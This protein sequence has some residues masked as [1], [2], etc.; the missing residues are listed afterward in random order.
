MF[1]DTSGLFCYLHRD[2]PKHDEAVSL[3]ANANQRFLTHN[4]VITELI[5][6]SIIR[7][8]P[9][10]QVLAFTL[11]LM[12]NPDIETVWIDQQLHN[13]GLNLLFNRQDKSYSLC[14]AV[15]FVLMKQF[16]ISKALTTDYHFEQEGFIRLLN[17]KAQN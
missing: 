10:S 14:D 6:L 4:Y 13:K 5:A 11:A 8:F 15:S 12:D 2:E 3:I 16:N 9:Q 7:R 17:P 1:L